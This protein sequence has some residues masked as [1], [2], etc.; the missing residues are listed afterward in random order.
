MIKFQ[1]G[2][3]ASRRILKGGYFKIFLG[4]G[5]FENFQF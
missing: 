5:V 4:G 1:F 3:G 2:A